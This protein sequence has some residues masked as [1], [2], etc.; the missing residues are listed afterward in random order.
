MTGQAGG[1][2]QDAGQAGGR[3]GETGEAGEVSGP[4]RAVLIGPPGAGK[5]TIGRRLAQ[6]LGTQVY[7]TDVA[8][9]KDTGRTI[10]QIF[11]ESGEA[12]FRAIE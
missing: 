8:I 2:S 11:A 10:P 5:S 4:P 9:E 3:S 6:A 12:E 7:D 1:R